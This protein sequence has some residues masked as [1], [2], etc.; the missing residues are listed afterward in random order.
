ME[1]TIAGLFIGDLTDCTTGDENM[2]VVHAAKTPCH[3]EIVG[4]DGTLPNNHKYYLKYETKSDLYLNIIDPPIPLLKIET[5]KYFL[6]FV[7]RIWYIEKRD[8]LI[9]CNQGKSRSPSLAI[10]ALAYLEIIDNDS[11][12]SARENFE[13]YGIE[14]TPGKGIERFLSDHWLE[15]I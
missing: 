6:D 13:S 7:Q 9:H 14:Y 5:F 3:Q 15:L 11:Y 10:L 4:Y 8:I 2:A 12:K 1:A